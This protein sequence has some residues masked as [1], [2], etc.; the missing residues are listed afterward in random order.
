M[1]N[2]D[3]KSELVSVDVLSNACA[4]WR[5]WLAA[6]FGDSRVCIFG[7]AVVFVDDDDDVVLRPTPIT[8]HIII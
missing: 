6:W 4:N 7:G 1:Y 3:E 8:H 2:R 5:S